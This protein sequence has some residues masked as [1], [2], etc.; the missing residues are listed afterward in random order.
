MPLHASHLLQPLNMGCFGPLKK[1]YRH[2]I[3]NL[4]CNH[5]NY[6]TKLEFLPAFKAAF[7]DLITK[8]N[9]CASF[10]GAGL[11]PYNPG[12][13]LS[14]LDVKLQ[15]PTPPAAEVAQW[16][17]KTPSNIIELG[18]QTTLI[19][20]QIQKH[21]DNSPTSIIKSLNR[22]SKGAKIMMHSAVLMREE[23]A[24]L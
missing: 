23:I 15:T 1:A 5:I 6:I 9:I 13:V 16:E 20:D 2:Q 14:K 3:E 19:R 22:L 4:V 7:D 8:N 12:A 21:Q 18:S 10:Q 17:S 11:V 24:S